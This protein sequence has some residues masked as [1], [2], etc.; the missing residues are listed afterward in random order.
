MPHRHPTHPNLSYP[1][2]LPLLTWGL[3]AGGVGLA[4]FWSSPMVGAA[5]S[6][7]CCVVGMVWRAGEPPVLAFCLVYQ[8]YFI[9]TGYI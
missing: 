2:Q 1:L 5:L 3:G 4:V 6:V 7:L 8:W 9:A